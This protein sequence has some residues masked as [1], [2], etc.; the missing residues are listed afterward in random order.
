MDNSKTLSMEDFYEL[1][2]CNYLTTFYAETELYSGLIPP[3]KREAAYAYDYALKWGDYESNPEVKFPIV[4]RESRYDSGKKMRDI[5]DNRSISFFLI[6]DRLKKVLEDNNITGWKSYPIIIYDKK[7][8][9]VEGYN[10]FSVTGRAGD[11]ISDTPFLKYKDIKD[12]YKEGGV[13]SY[14]DLS[15]WDGSDIFKLSNVGMIIVTE[16]VIKLFKEHKITACEYVKVSEHGIWKK[17]K[18]IR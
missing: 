11:F 14:F 2:S 15:T 13:G 12:W 7:G 3:E 17:E 8:N 10:G 9:L 6:S 1:S 18:I 5:L 16:K 4:W